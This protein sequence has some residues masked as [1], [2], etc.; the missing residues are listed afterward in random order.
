MTDTFPD[1]IQQALS[2]EQLAMLRRLCETYEAIPI[3][4]LF[5]Q[6]HG[7]YR[8]LKQAQA[9][10]EAVNIRMAGAIFSA[11]KA[12][13][14]KW[15]HIEADRQY[16]LKGALGYFI[17]DDD[18]VGDFDSEAGFMDDLEIVNACLRNADL[19]DLA[20]DPFAY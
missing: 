19:A 6:V 18:E 9:A 8:E 5:E 17:S 16:W 14:E 10:G 15:N 12:V 2:E 20:I 4:M 3:L 13:V 11:L 1:I 7:R